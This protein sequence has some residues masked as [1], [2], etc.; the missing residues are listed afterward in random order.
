MVR[1][2]PTTLHKQQAAL[3]EGLFHRSDLSASSSPATVSSC[4]EN[5]SFF[6]FIPSVSGTK[7]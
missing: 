3:A 2:F 7:H 4:A 6:Q 1:S 5:I